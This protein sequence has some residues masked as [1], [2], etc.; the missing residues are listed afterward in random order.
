M[1]SSSSAAGIHVLTLSP[2]YPSLH[3]DSSGC[4]I[5]EPLPWLESNGVR[6]SVL[7]VQPF[8]RARSQP[9]PAAPAAEY[10]SYPALPGNFGLPTSGA[11]LFA[12]ILSRVRQ[13][14]RL[15]PIHLIHA[16]GP[17]P[18]GHAAAL[19][20]R[21]LKIPFVVTVHGLDAFS[22]VQVQGHAGRWCRQVSAAVYRSARRVICISEHVRDAVLAGADDCSNTAVV[23]NGVDPDF[24][25]PGEVLHANGPVILSVGNLIPSKGHDSL[26]RAIARLKR[27]YPTISCEIIGAGPELS[28]LLGLA[29]EISIS[30]RVRFLGRQNRSIVANALRRCTL[31]ALPSHYEGLGC[32][33]LEAMASGK[34]AVACR[35]QGIEEII[36][37]GVNG[38]LV[39]PHNVEELTSTISRLLQDKDLR[40]Q[41]GDAGR[42]TV[43]QGFTL[44]HQAQRL[45]DAYQECLA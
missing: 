16:H 32:V 45:Y 33:Y 30:D 10:L 24:F 19:L 38:F 5:S 39:T 1:T 13:K 8:Y 27:S 40:H 35:G 26:L 29:A 36:Q 20:S 17:L 42:R 15:D 3:D 2:F 25:L 18:C 22:T 34:S 44:A 23:Y 28:R 6:H 4:F 14:H 41:I 11:L 31:F 7:T 43:L 9:H 37:A 12:R 21:E